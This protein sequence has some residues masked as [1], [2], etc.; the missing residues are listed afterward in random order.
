M[1]EFKIVEQE[2]QYYV[3]GPGGSLRS[4]DEFS[5]R[6]DEL[7]EAIKT[8]EM[9]HKLEEPPEQHFIVFKNVKI[10]DPLFY[11]SKTVKK[12]LGK[13]SEI[14]EQTPVPPGRKLSRLSAVAQAVK[15][16]M[17]YDR[18]SEGRM[19]DKLVELT[20]MDE[21]LGLLTACRHQA[22]ATV[23]ALAKI[24]FPDA[25]LVTHGWEKKDSRHALAF[26]PSRRKFVDGTRGK[27]YTVEEYLSRSGLPCD[28]FYGFYP[29]E[30]NTG[31][32][33]IMSFVPFDPRM[34]KI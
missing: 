22:P 15:E 30:K 24:G 5:Y 2:G 19:A 28:F 18:I 33:K 6:R 11:P 13:A 26:V 10:L 34:P 16:L 14:I 8:Y 17:P 3:K 7:L 32:E 31:A 27:V 4:V 12:I 9:E 23:A 1:G 29:Q 20:P 25:V 21:R